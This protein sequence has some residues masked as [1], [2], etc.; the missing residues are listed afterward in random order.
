MLEVGPRLLAL[1]ESSEEA[2]RLA[3]V[4]FNMLSSS[5]SARELVTVVLELF[6]VQSRDSFSSS[7]HLLL[8]QVL[9]ALPRLLSAFTRRRLQCALDAFI[10]VAGLAEAC[11][12]HV[13]PILEE[14]SHILRGRG[15][16][17][18]P[19]ATAGTQ[20]DADMADGQ[21]DES[22]AGAGLAVTVEMLQT[23]TEPFL[24]F[25]VALHS[26]VRMGGDRSPAGM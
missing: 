13:G 1:A 10:P 23:L 15:S 26:Q 6:D 18:A 4:Y 11:G 14:R 20:R 19:P 5:C 21:S 2:A 9:S 12:E 24:Q 7:M 25:A 17:T 22:A 16:V 3:S 8:L